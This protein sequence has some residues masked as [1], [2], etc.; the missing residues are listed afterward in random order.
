MLRGDVALPFVLGDEGA[1]T[2]IVREAA[3]KQ[4]VGSLVLERCF[5][6]SRRRSTADGALSNAVLGG[7]YTPAPTGARGG[8]YLGRFSG[9]EID[10]II[11]AGVVRGD[12]CLGVDIAVGVSV[13]L[14]VDFVI[15]PRQARPVDLGDQLLFRLQLAVR[16]W[17]GVVLHLTRRDRVAAVAAA[18]HASESA[19]VHRVEESF[20]GGVRRPCVASQIVPPWAQRAFAF[21]VGGQVAA[22]RTAGGRVSLLQQHERGHVH[23]HSNHSSTT[24]HRSVAVVQCRGRR[25]V[26]D[27]FRRLLHLRQLQLEMGCPFHGRVVTAHLTSIGGLSCGVQKNINIRSK[28]LQG[29]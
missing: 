17:I 23:F 7:N 14:G 27:A 2:S 13:T 29:I 5:G 28:G 19:W 10:G 3:H 20:F 24:V 4:P 11:I 15:V 12:V 8:G 18:S 16:L 9:G 6:R 22:P 1:L 21:R 26:W 25:R